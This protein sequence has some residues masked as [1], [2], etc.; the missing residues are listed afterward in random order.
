MPDCYEA[1][2]QAEA[3]DLAHTARMMRRSKCRCCD[4]H[5]LTDTYLDLSEFGLN[6]YVCEDCVKS[7]TH[8]AYELDEE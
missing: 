1:D 6:D 3:R 5:I 4:K 2:R 7:N 8:Y